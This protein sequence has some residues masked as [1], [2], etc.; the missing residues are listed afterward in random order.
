MYNFFRRIFS[1][2]GSVEQVLEPLGDILKRLEYVRGENES[3][4]NEQEE[5]A[6]YAMELAVVAKEEVARAERMTT[7]ITRFLEDE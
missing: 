4:A 1:K 7:K 3:F 2:R 6:A 5:I